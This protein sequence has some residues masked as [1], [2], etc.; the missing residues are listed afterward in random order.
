MESSRKTAMHTIVPLRGGLYLLTPT[1]L[2]L[3]CTSPSIAYTKMHPYQHILFSAAAAGAKPDLRG[4][5]FVLALWLA[6]EWQRYLPFS[7]VCVTTKPF[8]CHLKPPEEPASNCSTC[9]PMSWPNLGRTRHVCLLNV[10][11]P[12][13]ALGGRSRKNA[14]FVEC[15]GCCSTILPSC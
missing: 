14:V 15:Q 3:F 2:S 5:N 9:R 1:P 6:R 13:L 7:R 4:P 8:S 11:F 12:L 10:P